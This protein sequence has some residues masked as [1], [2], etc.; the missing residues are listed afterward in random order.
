MENIPFQH[1]L[2]L[3]LPEIPNIYGAS[4]YREF[5][6][7]LKKI[8]HIL[9]Q[10]PLEKQLIDRAL[11][12]WLANDQ[13]ETISSSEKQLAFQYKILRYALRCNIARHLTGESFRKFSIRLADSHLF[14]W[15]TCDTKS[16]D[17]VVLRS[18]ENHLCHQVTLGI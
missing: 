13:G 16:H 6:E 18:R 2:R 1:A 14:Q 7:V 9:T 15:F 4:D 10:T 3:P 11:S 17:N 8:D 12:Q 5:R